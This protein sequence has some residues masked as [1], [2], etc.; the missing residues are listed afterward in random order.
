MDVRCER[1]RAQYVFDD[2]QVTPGGLTVQCTNCGHVFRVKVKELVVTVPVKPGE[3]DSAP[4]PATAA[5]PKAPGTAAQDSAAPSAPQPAATAAPPAPAAGQ[6]VLSAIG[7]HK[8]DDKM[9]EWRVRQSNGNVFT[10]KELT[11]L[12]KWIVEQKVSRDDEIS[13][14]GDQWKRLGNIAELASFFQVVEAA[15]TAKTHASMPAM[16]PL[17]TVSVYP[18]VQA[19]PAYP[20]SYPPG[21]PSYPTGYAPQA[22]FPPPP[23]SFAVPPPPVQPPQPTSPPAPRA[24]QPAPAPAPSKPTRQARA[25]GRAVDVELSEAELG[26]VKGGRGWKVFLVLLL[27][28]ASGAAGVYLWRPELLGLAEVP[29][30]DTVAVPITI[31][32]KPA[33]PDVGDP[34]SPPGDKEPPP[35]QDSTPATDS[36]PLP[37]PVQVGEAPLPVAPEPIVKPEPPKPPPPARG[38]KQLLAD[39][40]RLRERGSVEKALDLYEKVIGLQPSNSRA[41]AGRGLCYLDL[42]QYALAEQ[43]FRSALQADP[44]EEDALLG[45]A[46]AA[47]YQGKK[48]EAIQHYERYLALHPDGED[49]VAARNAIQQLKE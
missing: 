14:S 39:A 31:D 6:P 27:L 1:C 37:A 29:S 35:P 23:P 15:E 47:R 20:G 32:M 10:F 4:I 44:E 40:D 45:L 42:Q 43:S 34:V 38:P 7:G 49:A 22:S 19:P 41:L 9:K 21:Y 12:Q 46:E 48:P 16:T 13:L 28:A 5:A 18:V 3:M 25:V 17:P 26:S 8:P 24:P 36:T 2:E 11:T 30:P 33:A